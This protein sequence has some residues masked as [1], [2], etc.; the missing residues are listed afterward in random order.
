MTINI[1]IWIVTFLALAYWSD[2]H[3]SNNGSV[4]FPHISHCL[5]RGFYGLSILIFG[6]TM[7]KNKWA[8]L[9]FVLISIYFLQLAIRLLIAWR[10]KETLDTR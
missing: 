7:P 3:T 9:I 8:V 1:L 2:K 10:K 4:Y 6:L 5:S